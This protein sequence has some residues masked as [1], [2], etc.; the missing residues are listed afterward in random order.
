MSTSTRLWWYR[1]FTHMYLCILVYVSHVPISMKF[2]GI[3]NTYIG[4]ERMRYGRYIL[5]PIPVPV[6]G[7]V[8]GVP[9]LRYRWSFQFA[10]RLEQPVL[11]SSTNTSHIRTQSQPDTPQSCP[12]K[13]MMK[14]TALQ[15]R[16]SLH[17]PC[18]RSLSCRQYWN[19]EAK[20][21]SHPKESQR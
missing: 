19:K 1:S 7:T 9:V 8:S 4:R 6:R 5:Q 12:G 16:V 11:L 2:G 21:Q 18:H 15:A 3:H 13:R 20:N 10:R 17:S 14:Q